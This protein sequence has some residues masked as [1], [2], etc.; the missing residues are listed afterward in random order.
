MNE[1]PVIVLV[2]DDEMHL[3]VAKRAIAKLQLRADVRAVTTGAA[4]L[5]ILG[6]EA[7]DSADS[8]RV[9]LVMLDIGLPDLSGWEVLER[10]RGSEVSRTLP[11]V[12]V[13]S[14]DRP[15]DV[16]RAYELGANSYLVKRHEPGRPG[17]YLA[18]AA[19]YWVELNSHSPPVP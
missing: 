3:V 13:S 8:G 5:Q 16:S 17:H 11:V 15:E 7:D 2:D 14:S 12:V 10:I 19:R 18:R 9:A 1:A 6:L 4:A